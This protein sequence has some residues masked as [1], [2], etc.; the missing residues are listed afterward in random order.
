MNLTTQG[1]ILKK[2]EPLHNKA[3]NKTT[4][5]INCD[6]NAKLKKLL[7]PKF[8]I[9]EF[10]YVRIYYWNHYSTPDQPL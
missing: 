1:K 8:L 3:V 7:V 2:I 10:G 5:K 4:L 9:G 6:L